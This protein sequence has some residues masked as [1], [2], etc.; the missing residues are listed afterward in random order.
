MS[1]LAKDGRLLQVQPQAL[2]IGSTKF[3]PLN[4]H[5]G[6]YQT[7]DDRGYQALLNYRANNIAHQVT[8]T[9]LLNGDVKPE[10]IKDKLVLI[11]TTAPS[12]KDL[13]LTPLNLSADKSPKTPGVLVHAQIASQILGTVLDG[14]SAIWFWSEPIE[15]LW[16]LGW[17]LVGGI[18][19][20]Q[21]RHPLWLGA[22][23]IVALGGL[24][25]SCLGLFTLAGWV[26]FVPAAI[27]L[28][29][30]GVGVV[31]YRLL[32]DAFHDDSDGVSQSGP[33]YESASVDDRP[34]IEFGGGTAIAVQSAL[35]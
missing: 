28:V 2:Q 20:W 12:A 27:A 25:A 26:P 24:F 14:R 3:L 16:I 1:Y 7:L 19:A 5:S 13:F 4:H 6:G 30:T 9:Q 18:I 33:V 11:G 17:A 34:S 32:H 23:N 22:A 8:L 31:V 21:L 10:W 35:G 29:T 15:G